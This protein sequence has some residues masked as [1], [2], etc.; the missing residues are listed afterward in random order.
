M[1]TFTRTL[2]RNEKILEED[3]IQRSYE[4]AG[5]MNKV[6]PTY[7]VRMKQV[8]QREPFSRV[9]SIAKS[10]AI[11]NTEADDEPTAPKDSRR[12]S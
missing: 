12:L 6:L 7:G 10:I 9:D 3:P 2:K 1:Q 4:D 11:E 8:L 5:S